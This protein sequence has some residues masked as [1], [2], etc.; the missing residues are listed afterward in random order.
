MAIL[1]DRNVTQKEAETRIKY[2]RLCIAI[3]RMW[4]TKCLFIPEITG[5]NGVVKKGLKKNL[6]A[7]PGKYSVDS[8]QKIA[9]LGTSTQY[10]L[11]RS[12][13]LEV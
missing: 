1:A 8:Q 2:K 9:V 5:T 6:E 12:L 4:N 10:G 11:Y 3:E 7:I 13:N